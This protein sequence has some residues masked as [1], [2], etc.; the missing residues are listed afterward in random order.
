MIRRA[1]FL[2]LSCRLLTLLAAAT[3]GLSSQSRSQSRLLDDFETLDG[4]KTVVSEGARLTLSS[5]E[6]KSGNAMVMTF[7]LSGVYGYTIA[8][9]EF[10]LDL[11][12]NYQ[13]TFDLRADAPVNNFEFKLID[14]QE[15]V[16]WIK[17]L[18]FTYPKDW[19]K[20]RIKRRHLSFAWGPSRGGVI[21]RVR[22]IEFVVSVSTGGKGKIWLDNF[23]FEPID[24]EAGKNAVA[25]VTASTVRPGSQLRIDAAGTELAGWQSN[26]EK[27]EQWLTVDF[28]R[29][30]EV[31][32]L[33]VDWDSSDY[34]A[35]YDVQFSD[36]GQ[37]WTTSYQITNGSGG[38]HAV[39]LHDEEGRFLRLAMNRSGKGQGYHCNRLE[40]KGPEFSASVNDFVR[41]LAQQAG[42]GLYPKAFLDRQSYWTVV[43]VNGDVK[44]A[45]INEQGQIEVDKLQFSLEPFL[46]VDGKLF[47]WN[48]VT[49]TASLLDGYLPVPS[50]TWHYG[51]LWT[52]T[53]QAVAAGV[54]GNSLLGV[55][56]S[57][58][59]HSTRGKAKLF[60]ALRPFQ[61][62][63]PW[64]ALNIAGGVS[65]IDSI[66]CRNGV[67]KVNDVTVI[68]MTPP[69]GFG[70]VEFDQGDITDELKQGR[71]PKTQEVIDHFGRAS[72]ALAFDLDMTSGDQQDVFLAVPFHGWRGSPA[73]NM[74][75]GTPETYYN[76]MLSQTRN[77]W[78]G[79][80]N[81]LTLALPPAAGPLASTVKSNL[82]YILINR[83]GPGIQPGSRS[84]ERSWIRDGSLTCSALLRLG[85]REEV[86]DFIDW[87]ARGQF[88]SGKIPCV[89]DAR[90]PD[91]V[92]EH[93]SH[94]Q[95]IYA[96][97]QYYLFTKDTAWLRGKFASVVKTVRYIQSLRAERKTETYKNGSPEQ[98]AC[99]GLVPESISHEGYWD[100]PRHSYWDDF[101][102]LR[103]LK[104]ATTIAAALGETA[105]RAEF[106][107]ERDDFRTDLYASMR[108]AIA[109]K[110]IDY[111]PG[112]VELGDFD[113]TSTTVG[114][115]PGG[116]LGNI[117]EPQLHNT[118]DRYYRFFSERRSRGFTNYTPYETR[119]I[120]TFVHLGQKQRAEEALNFFMHDRRP[121]EWNHW[122]EVV[123]QDPA[124]PKYIGDMPHTW[125]GSD[126]I[127]SVLDMFVYERE[128]DDAHVLCGAIPDAWV[129]DPA[130]IQ[131]NGLDTYCGTVSYSLRRTGAVVRAEVSGSFDAAH[132][133]LVLQSPLSSKPRSVRINGKAVARDGEIILGRLPARVE[134][135]Y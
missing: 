97:L 43:G 122:A 104:D 88:P 115:S 6:G 90:G 16:F 124:T 120:G 129:N 76:L 69:A 51:D 77:W 128:H 127:R 130:G 134:L 111:I 126:F 84:Y 135:T 9:K 32:G 39:Y 11:P 19:A 17:K 54:P 73:P 48:D 47:T 12:P 89:I 57:V 119:I 50:V 113:A 49:T 41:A 4:W 131:V 29:M 91:A 15:N 87:Y 101:F 66:S 83:D 78:E 55:R 112:C 118:F 61:V 3:L 1:G 65:R 123:W 133:K 106:A 132:H 107:A 95:F 60:I 36:D 10:A 72:G 30:K 100:V 103:G 58:T 93:D 14:D 109:Q 23:R 74:S 28:Q 46:Y 27:G 105:L 21:T 117:P 99:Y 64:Q 79:R 2:N 40:I 18:S 82:A 24:D 75:R 35:S 52:V 5:G 102:V 116:E 22:K 44:E 92:P 80:L 31:G 7:D 25:N 34:A 81:R 59:A 121:P 98:K 62:N 86:R 71:T 26:G 56:Y 42:P 96:V 114:V 63:P 108:S 110:K 13:F 33:V 45:L 125:V 38:K 67:V 70:A 53:I 20:Q 68:P 94:G 8:Q 37:E 85:N